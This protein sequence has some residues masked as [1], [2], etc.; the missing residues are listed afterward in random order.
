MSGESTSGTLVGWLQTQILST[1]VAPYAKDALPCHMRCRMEDAP[2]GSAA[3]AFSTITKDTALS[4][5]ITEATGLANTA[6]DTTKATATGGEVGIMRQL[7]KKAGRT[8]MLGEAG[9]FNEC[10]VDGI[11]MNLEKMET[12]CWAEFANASTSVGTSGSPMKAV[13]IASA[14]AQHT[15]NKSGGLTLVGF[16]HATAAKNVRN[17]LATSGATWLATGAAN[18]L[19][20]NPAPDGFMGHFMMDL[21]TNN[22]AA[23][24]SSDKVSGFHVD[25]SIPSQRL[26]CATGMAVW[27]MPEFATWSN[28]TFSGG[29]QVA[30]TCMYGL[31]EVVDAYYVKAATIA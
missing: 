31:V 11:F 24:A 8:S 22:L 7:T 23:T 5:T 18:N 2:Q 9:L 26:S 29:I 4:T 19:M 27:W 12:D 21:Y 10:L 3:Y 20:S 14:I 28:P 30:I 15:I 17:E 16:L 1:G 6:L 25:G 13:D